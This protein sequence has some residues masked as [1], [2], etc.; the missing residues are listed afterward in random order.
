MA[1]G[2]LRNNLARL[3]S[4]LKQLHYEP[5]FDLFG[6]SKGDPSAFLPVIHFVFLDYSSRLAEYFASKSYE[7]Y[8]KKDMRFIEAVYLLL[9]SEFSYK[10]VLSKEQFFSM[11]FAERKLLF[12]CDIIKLC[13]ELLVSLQWRQ[14]STQPVTLRAQRS[15][16]RLKR[17]A[18][19]H[20]AG[21]VSQKRTNSRSLSNAA[22]AAAKHQ[23]IRARQYGTICTTWTYGAVSRP[24]ISQAINIGVLL[25]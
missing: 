16:D 18:A 20:S 11:G 17:S 21:S 14:D 19:G 15:S 3:Q 24:A 4:E 6:A 9:R 12:V 5:N 7:L 13:K 23:D 2:D 25:E 8:G 10:P 22:A 1:T